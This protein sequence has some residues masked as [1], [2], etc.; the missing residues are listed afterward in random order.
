MAAD[1]GGGGSGKVASGGF[2]STVELGE[3]EAW[4]G[5]PPLRPGIHARRS[6]SRSTFET[7]S[8]ISAQQYWTESDVGG[9]G[10]QIR[11]LS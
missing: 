8:Q 4:P 2:V 10:G 6:P 3:L 7:P 1:G 5:A 9:G 11:M